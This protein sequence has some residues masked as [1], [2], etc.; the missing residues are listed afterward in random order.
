MPMTST[1]CSRAVARI[2]AARHHHAEVDHSVIIA[3]EH[4]ATMFLPIHARA[5]TVAMRTRRVA[6]IAAWRFFP[7]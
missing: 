6:G 1:F 4:D 3:A 2:F 7:S 5:L